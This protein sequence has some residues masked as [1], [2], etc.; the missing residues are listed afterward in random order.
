VTLGSKPQPKT[1]ALNPPH[2]EPSMHS[3]KHETGNPKSRV[4]RPYDPQTPEP[5]NPEALSVHTPSIPK[6]ATS[7][8]RNQGRWEDKEGKIA[9][10]KD[11]RIL[12]SRVASPLNPQLWTLN[13]VS[14]NLQNTTLIHK[15][16]LTPAYPACSESYIRNVAEN[17]QY[18][19]SMR[20]IESLHH[21]PTSTSNIW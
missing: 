1:R 21:T 13:P 18:S 17:K 20:Q 16:P 3:S 10:S 8:K 15:P 4:Q 5:L 19:I 2:P 12:G 6:P 14:I 11:H 9:K 7:A